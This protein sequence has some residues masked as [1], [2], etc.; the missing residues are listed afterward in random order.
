M[1]GNLDLGNCLEY[2]FESK[3]MRVGKWEKK[4]FLYM[5]RLGLKID[6]K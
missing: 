5:F 1:K 2:K 4:E 3:V 6:E